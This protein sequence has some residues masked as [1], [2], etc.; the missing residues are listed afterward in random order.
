MAA[1]T[2]RSEQTVLERLREPFPAEQVKKNPSGMH[3]VAIDGYINRL[4]D[5]LGLDYSTE[6]AQPVIVEL[7]P[8]TMKTSSGKRQ[9]MATVALHL[10]IGDS[11]RLGVGSDVSFDVDKAV[12]TA[13]AEAVKK[14]AHQFGIALELWDPERRDEIDRTNK[15]AGMSVAALKNKVFAL[16][17]ER[18]GKDKPTAKDMAAL[19]GVEPT[20]L[21]EGETLRRILTEQGAA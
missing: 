9:Y 6:L 17:R 1:R 12:K 16:A 15:L 20:D 7:L 14:A 21:Q 5:T 4:L 11:R 10:V 3:Y 19:F 2:T 18:T 13:L 8:D